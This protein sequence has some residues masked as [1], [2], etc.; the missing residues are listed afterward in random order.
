MYD[1]LIKA[2]EPNLVK[3]CILLCIASFIFSCLIILFARYF[4]NQRAYNDAFAIQSAHEGTVPRLG[5]VSV[6]FT[7]LTFTMLLDFKFMPS[8]FLPN[9]EIGILTWLIISAF[10]VFAVGFLEDI[11]YFMSPKK[12]LFGAVMSGFFVIV[13]FQV[14]VKEIGI[15]GIDFMLSFAPFAIVFTI[16]ATTGVINAFNLIDGLN[17]LASYVT[18]STAVSLSIIAFETNNYEVVRFLIVLSAVVLGFTVLNF[19]FGKLFLGDAGAYTLGHLLVWSAIILVNA[20]PK[21]SPFSILLIFFWPIADTGLAIWRR[22]KSGSPS[23]RPDR[24]HFH[25]LAMRFI[26]IRFI[27]RGKRSI[28][29]P[30]A[31]IILI[32]FITM[33]QIFGVLFWSNFLMTVW[34]TVFMFLLF[35]FTYSVGIIFAKKS[36]LFK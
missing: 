5:G 28:A 11:G 15:I 21:I 8:S 34:I 29:N 12:R 26:E 35:T 10:P 3:S 36:L 19:P 23:D 2:I 6:F 13:I 18:L 4:F 7:I 32:P 20:S 31:T 9:F 27:G 30:L 22:W 33:P 24:L 25:Q 17:G 1:F 14:W 16:F